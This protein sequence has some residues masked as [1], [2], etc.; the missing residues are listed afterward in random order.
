M[1]ISSDVGDVIFEL[2][3]TTVEQLIMV[4]KIMPFDSIVAK[5]IHSN[6][7]QQLQIIFLA[8]KAGARVRDAIY[9]YHLHQAIE[10]GLPTDNC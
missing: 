4:S 1:C 6:I 5:L 9:H 7:C 8:L 2:P 10:R 3:T